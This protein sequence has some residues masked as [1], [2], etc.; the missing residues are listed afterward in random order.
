MGTNNLR[1]GILTSM[2]INFTANYDGQNKWMYFSIKDDDLS[3]KY[4]AIWDKVSTNIK[5]EFDSKPVYN[6]KFLKTKIKS[7]G[8]ET[9]VF[10][11][12][13]ILRW[14]LTIIV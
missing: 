13:K 10:S 6:K 7:H 5:R 2:K 4:S 3:E 9:T 1:L 8:D 12:K 11:D 14:T